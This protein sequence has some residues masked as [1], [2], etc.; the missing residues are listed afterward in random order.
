MKQQ[1]F[2]L[3]EQETADGAEPIVSARV[4]FDPW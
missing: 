2:Y 4:A 1:E 3:N